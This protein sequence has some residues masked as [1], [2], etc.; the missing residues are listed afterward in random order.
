MKVQILPSGREARLLENYTVDT[1][2][3]KITIPGGFETD[4]ASVPQLF[5]SVVPPMGKYFIAA[6]LH[7]YLYRVPISR[8]L[9][10]G[11]CIDREKA[12]KVFLEELRDVKVSWWKRRLMYRAVRLGGNSSWVERQDR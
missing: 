10:A 7:D 9:G 6:V 11:R 2:V 5:W 12:D 4:F 1:M 8:K 3:G